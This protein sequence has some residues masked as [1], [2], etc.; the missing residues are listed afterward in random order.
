M[1]N[2][3][4][5]ALGALASIS[6]DDILYVVDDPSGTPTSKKI[7]WSAILG[8]AN[9]FTA[10]QTISQTAG[11]NV[12]ALSALTGS[13]SNGQNSFI[14]IGQDNSVGNSAVI[15]FQKN[16]TNV[17][18]VTLYGSALGSTG[19]TLSSTAFTSYVNTILSATKKLY[20]DGGSDTYIYESGANVLDFYSGGQRSLSLNDAENCIRT[21]DSAA[22]NARLNARDISF[23]RDEAGSNLKVKVKYADGTTIKIGT[24]ALV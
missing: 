5:S 3:K 22:A 24:I 20:L 15:G 7:A 14:T 2:T 17:F 12:N 11:A 8:T 1:V 13:M 23:Y 19:I 21:S 18:G 4:L 10:L 9:T 6:T 16:T